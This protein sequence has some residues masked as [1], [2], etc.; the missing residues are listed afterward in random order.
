MQVGILLSLQW[1]YYGLCAFISLSG[2]KK[3]IP[4]FKK[5]L[6]FAGEVLN[7]TSMVLPAAAGNPI[8]LTYTLWVYGICSVLLDRCS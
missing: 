6:L 4:T 8:N 2:I 5:Y 1:L 7:K 3:Y